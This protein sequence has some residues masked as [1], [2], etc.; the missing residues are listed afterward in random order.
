MADVAA[1][2]LTSQL[3]LIAELRW[4]IFRNSLR[5]KSAKLDLLAYVLTGVLGSLFAVGA[6]IGMGIGAYFMV[7]GGKLKLL[8]LLLWAVFLVWQFLPLM[9]ATSASGFD[10]RNLLRFPLRFSAFYLLGL[11]FGLADPAAVTALFWLLCITVGVTFAHLQFFFPAALLF[12]SFAVMNLLLSRMLF[13]WLERLLARRRSREALG[14]I[15]LLLLICFQFSGLFVERWGRQSA[16]ILIK[17]LP[18]ANLLPAGLPGKALE[19]LTHGNALPLVESTALL[20]VYAAACGL[21]LRV[22]LR[23][24]YLGEDLGETRAAAA[25]RRVPVPVRGVEAT[26][27]PAGVSAGEAKASFL[28][29]LIPSPAAAVLRKEIRYLLRNSSLLLAFVLPVILITF[30]SFSLSN[31]R[32]GPGN[33]FLKRMPD[34]AFPFGIA[35]MFLIIGQFAHNVFAFDGRGVQMFYLSPVRFGDILLG[36]NLMLAMALVLET[37]GVWILVSAL[38]GPPGAIYVL[39]TLCWL[40]FAMLVHFIVGN[41]LSLR[42]PRRFDFGQFRRRASGVTV[43]IGLGLQIVV[44]GLAALVGFISIWSGRLWIFAVVFLALSG[45]AFWLYLLT[46]DYYS[47]FA[48]TRRETLTQQLVR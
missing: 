5:T 35:Y 42:F 18:L 21:L 1:Q 16:P 39:A 20:L 27:A 33:A 37:A 41:W 4:R 36:K 26:R 45:L 29:G 7:S 13:S 30:I 47:R 9:L 15:F 44:L 34:L 3:R 22:R 46:L 32:H 40:L 6:G 24:Q 10:F 28:T 19:G 25:P 2:S 8:S 14:A 17:A 12:F 43:L 31:P 38:K 48:I 11:T 23:A